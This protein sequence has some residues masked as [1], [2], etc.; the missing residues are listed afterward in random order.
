M[1]RDPT[2]LESARAV[3]RGWRSPH[4][5]ARYIS[6]WEALLDRDRSEVMQAI[7]EDSPVMTAMRQVSPFVGVLDPRTRWKIWREVR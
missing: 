6:Q 5:A 7:V 2:L 4:V 3:V 1:D